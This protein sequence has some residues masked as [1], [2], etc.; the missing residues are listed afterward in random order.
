MGEGKLDFSG[1][2]ANGLVNPAEAFWK[3]K[4]IADQLHGTT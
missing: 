3:W 4:S 2:N 1:D